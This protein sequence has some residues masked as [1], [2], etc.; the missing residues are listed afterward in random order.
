MLE[1][2]FCLWKRLPGS[3]YIR[4]NAGAPMPGVILMDGVSSRGVCRPVYHFM[5]P[6]PHGYEK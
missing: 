5:L 2:L 6:W 3:D 1:A 4:S